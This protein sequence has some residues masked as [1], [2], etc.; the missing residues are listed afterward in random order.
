M[1]NKKYMHSLLD[2]CKI[3]HLKGSKERKSLGMETKIYTKTPW[4][5]RSRDRLNKFS[6]IKG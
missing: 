2:K 5:D 6:K 4:S 3:G 1:K